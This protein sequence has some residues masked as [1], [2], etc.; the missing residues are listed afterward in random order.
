MMSLSKTNPI[1]RDRGVC[2]P[3]IHIFKDRAYL[4][5]SHDASPS[6]TDYVMNDWQVWSSDDLVNWVHESTL[7][8]EDTYMG[9]SQRCWAVDAAE[10]N[11]KYY[12]YFSNGMT[13]TGVAVADHPGGPFRDAL[14]KPL[15]AADL[16]PTRSYD[17]SVFIDDDDDQSAY[18]IFGTPVWAGGDSYYIA[19]LGDDMISLAEKPEKIILDDGADDKP[20]LHKFGGLYYLSWA[21]FYAVSESV[22]GPYRMQGNIGASPDHGSFFSW[23]GQWFHA[24]TIFDPTPHHRASGICYVHY[25]ADGRM[26]V[27]PVIVEHGVGHYDAGLNRIDAT[28]FM[29]SAH[30]CKHANP[31]YGFDISPTESDAYL[32]FP[33]VHDLPDSPAISFFAAYAPVETE[34][35]GVIEVRDAGPDGKLLGT[36]T[37]S[38]TRSLHWRGY[39]SWTTGELL[40]T[41][42]TRS[43]DLCLAFRDF[44]PGRLRLSFFRVA[45]AHHCPPV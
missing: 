39:R 44:E 21:S 16:T 36:C 32:C 11:G 29:E 22:Y 10:R 31:R 24:F 12:L 33:S 37:V 45:P 26:V 20:F 43:A 23:R 28:W 34:T 13:D 14:G 18:I 15:L 25:H 1:I 38:D 4:Y 19:R 35:H 5:A 6:S 7:R 3:H 40:L 42:N 9:P 41:G 17:P 8:P 2:D 27:D 30:V